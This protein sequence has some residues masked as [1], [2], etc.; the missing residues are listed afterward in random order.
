MD[1]DK[2]LGLDALPPEIHQPLL[3]RRALP[4]TNRFS[5]QLKKIAS[6]ECEAVPRRARV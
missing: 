3:A 5:S 6:H 2:G 4:M 1:R